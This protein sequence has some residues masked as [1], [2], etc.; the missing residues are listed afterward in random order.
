M[1]EDKYLKQIIKVFKEPIED[2]V[3]INGSYGNVV[4]EINNNWIFR[5]SQSKID[6]KQLTL[7]KL[8]LPQFHKSCILNIPNIKYEGADFIGYKKINGEPFSVDV[9]NTL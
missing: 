1:N 7:E 9:F 2:Y 5:F 6:I 4:V 3:V 8:F